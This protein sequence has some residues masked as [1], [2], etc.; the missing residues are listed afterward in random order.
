MDDHRLARGTAS[1]HHPQ[2][3]VQGESQVSDLPVQKDAALDLRAV[4]DALP[5]AIIVTDPDARILL[6]N[7]P[8]RAVVRVGR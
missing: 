3:Q 6:W 2:H 7:Q 8:G 5:R 1:R 4:I